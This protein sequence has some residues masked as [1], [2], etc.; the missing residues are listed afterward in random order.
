VSLVSDEAIVLKRFEFAETS[1]VVHLFTRARGRLGVLAKGAYREKS[2]FLG[3]LDL[4]NRLGVVYS[5][6][7]ERELQI[8][9]EADVRDGHP[10][11][12]RDLGR[13][14]AALY[15]AD[16]VAEAAREGEPS[17]ALYDLFAETLATLASG[18]GRPGAIVLVFELAFLTMIGL[19]PSFEACPS[20]GAPLSAQG[21]AALAPGIGGAVCDRCAPRERVAGRVPVGTLRAAG[22]LARLRPSEARRVRLDARLERG[23][24]RAMDLYLGYHFERIPRSRRHLQL[25]A[26]RG[27]G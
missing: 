6:R 13:F 8:L 18:E 22:R 19:G 14:A 9:T 26:R 12:H 7:P 3:S 10:G 27:K 5:Y 21:S 11:L 4:L 20:C 16:L 2:P 15:A 23:L 25:G 17:P 24:R 1:L